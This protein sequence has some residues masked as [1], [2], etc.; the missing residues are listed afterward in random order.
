MS[1]KFDIKSIIFTDCFFYR[2]QGQEIG[3]LNE[4]LDISV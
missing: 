3:H 1:C 4:K 2:N